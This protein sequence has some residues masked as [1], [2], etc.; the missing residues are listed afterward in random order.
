MDDLVSSFVAIALFYENGLCNTKSDPS[1]DASSFETGFGSAVFRI[2]MEG[3]DLVSEKAGSARSCVSDQGFLLR[4]ME[5][6]F[7]S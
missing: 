6:Q 4:K 1:I 7:F 3:A 5:T 2:R